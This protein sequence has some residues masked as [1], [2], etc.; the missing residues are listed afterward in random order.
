MKKRTELTEEQKQK[1]REAVRRYRETPYGKKMTRAR[2]L[3]YNYTKEDKMY[4]RET[5]DFDAKWVIDNIFSKP[6]VYCG[7]TDWHKL[8]CDRVNNAVGHIKSNVVC[9]CFHCN[10]TRPKE[11]EWKQKY[12]EKKKKP[13]QMLDKSGRILMEFQSIKD[14]GEYVG[15]KYPGHIG[16]VARGVRR[17]AYGYV[18][19]FKRE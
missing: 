11:E 19:Q 9:S 12:G 17:E 8:G 2:M 4:G 13:I 6:C 16:D 1:H 7:E 15:V 3:I 14:A 18:W 10:M 5:P